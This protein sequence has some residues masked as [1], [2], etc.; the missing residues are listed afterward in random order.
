MSIPGMPNERMMLPLL[1]K[2]RT[3]EGTPSGCASVEWNPAGFSNLESALDGTNGSFGARGGRSVDSV[4]KDLE[5]EACSLGT[6][7][8]GT[9]APIESLDEESLGDLSLNSWGSR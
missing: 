9:G 2:R 3:A 5:L 6:E 8:I 4:N 7:S 1:E